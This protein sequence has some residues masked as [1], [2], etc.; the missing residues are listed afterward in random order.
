VE[1][2]HGFVKLG[3]VTSKEY[4]HVSRGVPFAPA[5]VRNVPKKLASVQRV[6]RETSS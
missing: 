3:L 2:L 4:S 6:E 5:Y 1:R